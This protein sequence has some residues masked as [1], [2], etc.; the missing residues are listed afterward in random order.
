MKRKARWKA[1]V[2]GGLIAGALDLT[3]PI[4]FYGLRGVKAIRIPQSIASGL[5]GT[6]ALRGGWDAAA[7]GVAL[8]FLIA[9]TW[10]AVFCFAAR[11]VRFLARHWVVCGLLYGGVIYLFMNRVVLPLSRV[12]KGAPPQGA[13]LVNGVLAVV[14]LVGLPIAWAANRYQS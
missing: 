12:A 9:L 1:V 14:I 11:R 10:A 5:I 6:R 4:V 13:V 8:H 2:S 7:L 3:D